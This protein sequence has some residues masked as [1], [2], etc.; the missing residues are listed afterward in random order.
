M[1]W[2]EGI[3]TFKAGEALA[4]KRRVKIETGTTTTPPEVVYADAGED[5]IGVT[6]YAVA[7]AAMVV[8]KMN[9]H[10][11]TFEIECLVD[12]A[13]ARGTVLYGG[14]SGVVTDASSGTAQGIALEVGADGGHIECAMWNVKSTTAATVSLLD[15]G[16]FT[17]AATVEAAIA[18]IY[19]HL[20][21][22]QKTIP[23]PLGSVTQEDGTHLLKQAGTV[24]GIAQISDKEHVINIPI[25]CSAGDSLGFSVA[26]PQDLDETADV[27]VHVL[28]GKDADN[29]ALTLDCEVYPVA[30]G[31]VANADIQDTAATAIVAAV[32]DL[33]FTCGFDG[34]LAAPGGLSVVLA[35]G[36][37]NDGDA[38][39]I[40]AIW[41]EYTAK[42]LAA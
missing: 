42:I 19:Q 17:A 6:E 12:S 8:V 5:F 1:S 10:P 15:S 41:I 24:A 7:D 40:Y 33:P 39:Y 23:V 4:A 28:V 29:D 31:D 32:T 34:V 27:I 2:N 30:A 37:T 13:I 18:E 26:V 35:Q 25:N 21:S 36:G 11:G 9:T 38:V 20:V 3:K 14:A 16:A 22:A